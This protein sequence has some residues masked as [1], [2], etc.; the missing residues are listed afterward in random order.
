[1]RTVG[2]SVTAGRIADVL[3]TTTSSPPLVLTGSGKWG[4][5]A[6]GWRG[7]LRVALSAPRHV[8]YVN[9]CDA[10]DSSR[11]AQERKGNEEPRFATKSVKAL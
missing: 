10:G 7:R 5:V 11:P 4:A 9:V 8:Y 1:M 6:P 2:Y 3:H